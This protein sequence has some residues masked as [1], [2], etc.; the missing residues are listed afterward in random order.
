MDAGGLSAS[1]VIV[2]RYISNAAQNSTDLVRCGY[3]TACGTGANSLGKAPGLTAATAVPAA[4]TVSAATV[5]GTATVC[6]GRK[7]RYSVPAIT[8][9][10][11]AAVTGYNWTFEG[12]VLH[13]SQ[14]TTYVID[15][16][17][18]GGLSASRVIVVR[19]ISNAAQNTSDLVKCGYVTA[20]GIG[21]NSL[22]KAP[23]LTA[24]LTS[25]PPPVAK[26][27]A[28]TNFGVNVYP[29][30]SNGQFNVQ[31]SGATSEAV[32]VRI[33][34]AQGRYIKAVRAAGNG[35]ITLGSDLRAGSY[36]LEV[37]QGNNVKVTRVLKF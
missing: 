13:A 17:D 4:P 11:V 30:P 9:T 16:M 1:R 14:G 12:S 34:D 7:V 23:G 6:G 32:N 3:V 18:A 8:S 5:T 37:R 27:S 20:C 10:T 28:A 36:L 22:G 19:Y 15:S 31:L 33:L 26:V 35:V 29:N 25:C 24:A 21:A 2:V